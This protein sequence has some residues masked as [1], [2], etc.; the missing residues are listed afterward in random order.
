MP[1]QFILVCDADEIVENLLLAWVLAGPVGIGVKRK[2]IEVA[3]NCNT[4]SDCRCRVE[5]H[6]QLTQGHEAD[7]GQPKTQG[8]L[9]IAAAAWVNVVIPRSTDLVALLHDDE[10]AAMIAF[11]EIDGDAESCRRDN[12]ASACI[13]HYMSFRVAEALLCRHRTTD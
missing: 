7:A 2:G 10:A 1:V 4:I 3:E 5:L 13:M 6:F 8:R 9:T 12:W 11:D